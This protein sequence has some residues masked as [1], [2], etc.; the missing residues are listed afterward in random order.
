MDEKVQLLEIERAIGRRLPAK[1]SDTLPWM[2][3]IRAQIRNPYAQIL[4]GLLVVFIGAFQTLALGP[5]VDYWNRIWLTALGA[6]VAL[7]GFFVLVLRGMRRVGWW[8]AA[9]A[10]VRRRGESIPTELGFFS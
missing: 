2:Y 1:L 4:F 5:D 6:G 3:V 9:R 10:E 8:H 7:V